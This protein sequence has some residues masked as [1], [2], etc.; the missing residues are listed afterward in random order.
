M[1]MQNIARP[2]AANH[3]SVG[4]SV[5]MISLSTC[6]YVSMAGKC[7]SADAT[8]GRGESADPKGTAVVAMRA[9]LC[10]RRR[11]RRGM[12][13]LLQVH[14]RGVCIELLEHVIG[15]PVLDHLRDRPGLIRDVAPRDRAR[16][17]RGG[18]RGGEL[19]GNEVALL[20]RGPRFGLTDALDTE[21]A[22]FHDALGAHRDVGVELPV[23][24][25]GKRIL[26]AV[27]F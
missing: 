20:E 18:A 15:P 19:V 8:L 13:D 7:T 16:R 26:L 11:C 23:Q 4:R 5:W 1:S 24:G 6:S 10:L 22:L 27:L 25:P 3:P 12:V 14:H 2:R 9:S 17:T 21:R